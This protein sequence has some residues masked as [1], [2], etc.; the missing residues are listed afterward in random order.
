MIY[1]IGLIEL[2]SIASGI[3]VADMMLKTAEVDL[4]FAG[5]VCPGKYAALVTGE[6]AAVENSVQAGLKTG[7]ETVVDHFVLPMVHEAVIPALSG[8]SRVDKLQALGIIETFSVASAIVA[9]DTAAK[10]ALVELIEIRLGTGI[11]G[12]SFVTM[13]GEVAAVKASVDAGTVSVKEKGMLVYKTVIPSPDPKL[14]K[15]LL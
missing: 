10:A 15:A 4:I 1:S 12:K 5:T 11:G 8:T 14:G 6:V 7:G 13:T 3:E 9:A 2:N